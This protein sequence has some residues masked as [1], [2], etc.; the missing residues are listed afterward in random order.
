MSRT[1]LKY[2]QSFLADIWPKSSLNSQYFS[3]GE[4][5]LSSHKAPLITGTQN[6]LIG[7]L[8]YIGTL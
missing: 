6:N 1:L 8:Q 7:I 2:V 4:R 5:I 3:D